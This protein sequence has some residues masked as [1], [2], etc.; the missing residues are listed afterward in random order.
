[1]GWRRRIFQSYAIW[2]VKLTKDLILMGFPGG[3]GMKNLT[4]MQELQE[5]LV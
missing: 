1:M 3:S 5:M 2:S 4:A